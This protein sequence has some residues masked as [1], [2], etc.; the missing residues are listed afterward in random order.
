MPLRM[1]KRPTVILCKT[2]RT[3]PDL[4]AALTSL[5]G[6][7]ALTEAAAALCA[8][9]GGLHSA[10]AH[11]A[12][13]ALSS[14]AAA[15]GRVRRPRSQPPPHRHRRPCRRRRH[16]RHRASEW[17]CARSRE[18]F[19]SLSLFV[20]FLVVFGVAVCVWCDLAQIERKHSG[21]F[22]ASPRRNPADQFGDRASQ[23]TN[24]ADQH[25]NS[26]G[27]R[28]SSADQR[29]NSAGQRGNSAEPARELSRAT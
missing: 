26:A 6:R 10:N 28:G 8:A 21:E 1:S 15:A 18:I 7:A 5:E 14:T 4:P 23:R 29:G 16:R 3:P 27:Q 22:R 20:C 17:R 13:C 19:G 2:V 11:Y 12:T 25:G 24:P 9:L